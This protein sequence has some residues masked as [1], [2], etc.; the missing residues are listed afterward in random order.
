MALGSTQPLTEMSTRY[1]P[2]G[3]WRS[4]CKADNLTARCYSAVCLEL[5]M[6]VRKIEKTCYFLI[7]KTKHKDRLNLV[8][9]L[10]LA[11][12]KIRPRVDVLAW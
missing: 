9:A 8:P 10:I 6:V 5:L 2:G 1:L 11:L 3:K 7:I 12:T 4:S